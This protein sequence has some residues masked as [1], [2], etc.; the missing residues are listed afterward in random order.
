MAV[1]LLLLFDACGELTRTRVWQCTNLS[2]LFL[3][4]GVLPLS[5]SSTTVE[6]A[7]ASST[8]AQDIA[9]SVS[10]DN[11]YALAKSRSSNSLNKMAGVNKM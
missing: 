1:I 9:K 5:E 11:L 3:D 4:C 10:F 2:V 8:K 7:A 6:L